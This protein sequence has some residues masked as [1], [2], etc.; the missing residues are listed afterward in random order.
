M[1]CNGR[2]EWRGSGCADFDVTI[3]F[4][5]YKRKENAATGNRQ[6]S[7]HLP[8]TFFLSDRDFILGVLRCIMSEYE[9]DVVDEIIAILRTKWVLTVRRC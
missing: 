3:E 7:K 4:E 2:G 9:P 6:L 8:S 5:I 1:H